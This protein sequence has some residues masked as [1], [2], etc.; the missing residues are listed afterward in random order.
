[1]FEINPSKKKKKKKTNHPRI[2]TRKR[3]SKSPIISIKETIIRIKIGTTIII[4]LTR[5]SLR[6]RKKE[7]VQT[8]KMKKQKIHLIC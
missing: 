1:M 3:G 7:N 6:K 8:F 5:K 4:K 2:I